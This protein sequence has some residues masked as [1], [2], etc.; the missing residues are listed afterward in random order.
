MLFAPKEIRF[1]CEKAFND[2]VIWASKQE[3]LPQGF[4][5]NKDPDQPVH[6]RRLISAFVIRL[7]DGIISKLATSE[8]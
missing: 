4:A 8:I 3:N 6:L 1:S 2:H 5:N 7:L